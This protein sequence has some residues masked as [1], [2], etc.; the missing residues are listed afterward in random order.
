VSFYACYFFFKR[1]R[2]IK[3]GYEEALLLHPTTEREKN[4][5]SHCNPIGYFKNEEQDICIHSVSLDVD[6]FDGVQ[7]RRCNE[8]TA[9]GN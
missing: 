4:E 9:V 3:I 6:K 2:Y 8:G 5:H 7:R 1:S